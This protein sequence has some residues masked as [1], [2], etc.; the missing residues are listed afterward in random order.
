MCLAKLNRQRLL[1]CQF[2]L[3]VGQLFNHRWHQQRRIGSLA[4]LLGLL[5]QKF[6]IRDFLFGFGQAA[7]LLDELGFTHRQGFFRGFELPGQ[8]A[9]Q[10]G[11]IFDLLQFVAK[12]LNLQRGAFPVQ[13]RI[14]TK[15]HN[16]VQCAQ[17]VLQRCA[18][19]SQLGQVYFN[20][21]NLVFQHAAF[22]FKRGAFCGIAPAQHIAAA[23][24]QAVAVV[25]FVALPAFDLASL[26]DGFG[27]PAKLRFA[28]AASE[29]KAAMQFGLQP[30]VEG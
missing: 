21:A 26:G 22:G 11:R 25:F 20:A 15:L 4:L 29:V 30:V 2:G 27:F 6:H 12:P 16:F 17:A 3:Q 24:V 14:V 1:F 23:V 7:A 5:P 28:V 18:L 8:Q 13:F 19:M 9:Q 10:I